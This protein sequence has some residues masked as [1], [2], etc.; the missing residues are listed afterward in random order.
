[1]ARARGSGR[2]ESDPGIREATGS[3]IGTFPNLDGNMKRMLTE[4]RWELILLEDPG[5]LDP[6]IDPSRLVMSKI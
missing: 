6:G 3:Y 4:P 5:Q 1:M 2:Q